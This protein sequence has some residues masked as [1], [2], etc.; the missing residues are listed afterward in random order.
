MVQGR[1]GAGRDTEAGVGIIL[2][3]FLRADLKGSVVCGERTKMA[4][5]WPNQAGHLRTPT[6]WSL[7][8]QPPKCEAT[9]DK[10]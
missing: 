3:G 6:G 9:Q 10:G 8:G 5:P 2:L 1:E 4:W 7:G